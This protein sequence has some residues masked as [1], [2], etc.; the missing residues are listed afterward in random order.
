MYNKRNN[1]VLLQKRFLYSQITNF[2]GMYPLRIPRVTCDSFHL[3]GAGC[4]PD[5]VNMN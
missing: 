2:S 3:Y 1:T 5:S 4:F